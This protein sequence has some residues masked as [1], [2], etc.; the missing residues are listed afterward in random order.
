MDRHSRL[1]AYFKVLLPLAALALMST[2]F[3]LS[4]S[5]APTG[6]APFADK[7][8][9][10]RVRGQQITGAF[11]SGITASGDEITV[12]ASTAH[13]A[14]TDGSADAEELRAHMTLAQGGD[15]RLQS[16]TGT[17]DPTQSQASFRGNVL[18]T[19]STGYTVRT[20]QLDTGLETL[21]AETPGQVEATGPFG[22]ITAGQMKIGAKNQ[23][24]PVHM[25][26]TKG[27]KLVYDP[28]NPGKD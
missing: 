3:L 6:T 20:Q 22:D 18:I 27:V 2:L 19:T 15:I 4:R 11:F 7:D 21:A 13:P 8:I 28:R 23:D 25:L 10:D 16:D 9:E 1:V 17:V 5:I 26:F 12:S 24:A 14:N